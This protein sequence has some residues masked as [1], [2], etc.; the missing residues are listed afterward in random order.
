MK[1]FQTI[2]MVFLL[3]LTSINADELKVVYDLSTRDVNKIERQFLD[4]LVAI[5]KYYSSEKKSLKAIV[6][7]SGRSY[8]YF[9]DDLKDSP[10]SNDEDALG[11]QAY[12]QLRFKALH[13]VYGVT[14]QMCSSGMKARGIKHDTLYDF[15][16]AEKMKSVYLIDAQNNG[17]AYMPIH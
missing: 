16:E 4:S 6:V 10:Y 8:K 9:I 2:L 7:I 11:I 12:F 1:K 3:S 13:D 15:I 5:S 14:F 17:Y